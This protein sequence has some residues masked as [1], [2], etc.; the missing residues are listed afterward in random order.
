MNGTLASKS[1]GRV[2]IVGN[3]PTEGW[4]ARVDASD[5]VVRFN[6]APGYGSTTGRRVTHLAL[7]NHG[8]QMAEWLGDPG[9]TQRP[10]VASAESFLLPFA[11]KDTEPNDADECCWTDAAIA[12]ISTLGR[13]VAILPEVVR[14]E[15][16]RIVGADDEVSGPAP[17]TGLLATLHVLRSI[18]TDTR[19]DLYGFAFAGWSG[20]A[21]DRERGFLE[22]MQRAGR[23]TIRPLRRVGP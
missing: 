23:L 18:S 8:G 5:W 20:H 7:V 22:G 6:N 17:S 16:R 21:F 12:R 15:A 13:P 3:A 14:E 19:V 11:R 9:F 1:P 4:A 10:V 2:A